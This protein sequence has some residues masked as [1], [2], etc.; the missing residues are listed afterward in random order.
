MTKIVQKEASVL[1]EKAK[2]VPISD[3]EKKEIQMVIQ[4]MKSALDLE[5]DGV[6]IAA[7]Q[8]GVSLCIFIVSNKLFEKADEE[9]EEEDLVFINPELV[10]ASR[11]K[12]WLEEGCLSARWLYGK[13]KRSKKATVKAYNE[14]GREFTMGSSG[15]L[16]QI[17]QHEID[18]LNGILFID[19]AKHLEEI[20][21]LKDE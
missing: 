9:S 18:H 7:P 15:L 2:K 20:P 12:I 19:K 4:N 11:E 6:A 5:S 13:V 14:H 8:I 17:F 1:R 10:K 21:P 16:A 3:I